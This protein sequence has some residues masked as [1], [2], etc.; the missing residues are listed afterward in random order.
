MGSRSETHNNKNN[1]NSNN[2]DSNNNDSNCNNSHHTDSND[3]RIITRNNSHSSNSISNG[4]NT[5]S[6]NKYVSHPLQNSWAALCFGSGASA[7]AS[8]TRK[9]RPGLWS[10][11]N[12]RMDPYSSP[13]TTPLYL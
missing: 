13:Y 4:N 5:N 3:N 8:V 12:E 10:A 7:F 6:D 9:L 2:P 11:R 1:S